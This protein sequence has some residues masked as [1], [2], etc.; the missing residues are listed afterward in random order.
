[1]GVSTVTV[2][3]I[4]L[5]DGYCEILEASPSAPFEV[6]RKNYRRLALLLHPDKNKNNPDAT[7]SFQLV[8]SST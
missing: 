5:G 2:A 7:A 3:P 8:I 4:E 1:V 6:V